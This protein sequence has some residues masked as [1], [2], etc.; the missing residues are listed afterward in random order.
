MKIDTAKL[1][2]LSDIAFKIIGNTLTIVAQVLVK[3]MEVSATIAWFLMKAAF[4]FF[5]VFLAMM[6]DS[7]DDI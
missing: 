5:I 3:L 6:M 4:A 7:Q 1:R 2:N